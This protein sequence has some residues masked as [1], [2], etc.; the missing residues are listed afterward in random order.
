MHAM[1]GSDLH[2]AGICALWDCKLFRLGSPVTCAFSFGVRELAVP[3][4]WRTIPLNIDRLLPVV[5][6]CVQITCWAMMQ[7]QFSLLKGICFPKVSELV[8]FVAKKKQNFRVVMFSFIPICRG[9]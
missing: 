1:T 9:K 4:T 3:H 6:T 5:W 8:T 2:R 7:V